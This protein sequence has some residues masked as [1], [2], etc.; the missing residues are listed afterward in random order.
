MLT[1]AALRVVAR[2]G[3]AAASTRRIA[4]EAGVATGVV[5]YAYRSKDELLRDVALAATEELSD[6][7]ISTVTAGGDLRETLR[8]AL[9]G[10]WRTVEESPETQ[11]ALYE[12][13]TYCLRTPG[14]ADVAAD[15]YRSYTAAARRTL[16]AVAAA[17]GVTFAADPAL[18]ARLL[19]GVL[20]GAM[21]AWMADRDS[22]ATL[23]ALDL[24]IDALV[25]MASQ[26]P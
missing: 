17:C 14:L 11:L 15:Q 20:D 21:L 5:H 3:V 2:E 12:L 13:T 24:F 25:G 1:R 18:L 4:A 19:G 23:A 16:D 7:A 22:T 6:A 9:R 8:A 10:A 26:A